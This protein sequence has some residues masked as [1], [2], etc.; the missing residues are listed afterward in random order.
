MA[1][2]HVLQNAV[3]TLQRALFMP[4]R[5]HAQSTL[6]LSPPRGEP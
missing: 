6:L 4:V 1:L 2:N 5:A 3:D